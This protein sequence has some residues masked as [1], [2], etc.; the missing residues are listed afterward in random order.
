MDRNKQKALENMIRSGRVVPASAPIP[1]WQTEFVNLNSVFFALLSSAIGGD[2][3]NYDAARLDVTDLE[4]YWNYAQMI[5]AFQKRKFA[6][7]EAAARSAVAAGA[8]V[9]VP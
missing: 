2:L 7:A 5:V 1:E 9:G 4:L 6:E 3:N 8:A